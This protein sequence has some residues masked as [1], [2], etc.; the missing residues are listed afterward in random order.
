[1]ARAVVRTGALGTGT[2]CDEGSR[3]TAADACFKVALSM[4][5]AIARTEFELT[6]LAKIPIWTGARTGI[7]VALAP[8]GAVVEAGQE[9]AFFT[10][11]RGITEALSRLM[12]ASTV[13]PTVHFR[14]R[15]MS[16]QLAVPGGDAIA[17]L[18]GGVAGASIVTV[19]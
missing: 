12:V 19:V 14:A 15:A 9:K 3:I 5:M 10:K 6:R 17:A 18:S 1:M 2:L 11:I 7:N 4:S 8:I 16:A 13:I